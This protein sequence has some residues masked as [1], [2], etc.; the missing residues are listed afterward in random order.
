[1]SK[2]LGR[3]GGQGCRG[4]ASRFVYNSYSTYYVFNFI[5]ILQ[6]EALTSREILRFIQFHVKTNTQRRV[7]FFGGHSSHLQLLGWAG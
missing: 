5:D 6:W 3:G 1:M 7:F 2:A 4:K